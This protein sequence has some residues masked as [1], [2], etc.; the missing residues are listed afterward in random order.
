[1]DWLLLPVFVAACGAAAAT[2]ALFPPDEWYRRIPKPAWTPPD[3]VFP[4]AWTYL[5][6]AL[7]VAGARVVHHPEAG[8]ALAFWAMQIAFNA[9]WTPVFFGLRRPGAAL[10]VIGF[11]FAGAAGLLASLWP[12][13]RLAFWLV[14]PYPV[15]IAIAAALNASIW[16]RLRTA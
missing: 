8:P 11:L 10:P 3:W 13:D 16:H 4:L 9:L 7:A 5:Y 15:W 6:L 1:M 14:A 2:G 12:L